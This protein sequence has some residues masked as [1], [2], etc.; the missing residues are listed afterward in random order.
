MIAGCL[1][2]AST[3]AATDAITLNYYIGF[4]SMVQRPALSIW[5][6]D[7]SGTAVALICEVCGVPSGQFHATGYG[8]R[9]AATAASTAVFR[10]DLSGSSPSN[11]RVVYYRPTVIDWVRW[12]R[13]M[14]SFIVARE[15]WTSHRCQYCRRAFRVALISVNFRGELPP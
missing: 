5:G 8:R 11:T 9:T 1:Q 10:A 14:T 12:N 4:G 13:H 6:T 15:I 7:V 3:A 2:S